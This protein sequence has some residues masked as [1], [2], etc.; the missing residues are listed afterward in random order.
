MDLWC[1]VTIV[2]YTRIPM[3][4]T[5]LRL[6]LDGTEW[7]VNKFFFRLKSNT[8][9][10]FDRISLIGNHKEDYELHFIFSDNN[11]PRARSGDLLVQTDNNDEPFPVNVKFP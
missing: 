3:K 11:Y 2:N 9:D 10:K 1:L 4:I 6:L 7:P 8:R 5:P